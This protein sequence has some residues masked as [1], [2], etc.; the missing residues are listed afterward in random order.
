MMTYASLSAEGIEKYNKEKKHQ[1]M[2]RKMG[3]LANHLEENY[4]FLFLLGYNDKEI[5]AI[6]NDANFLKIADL[7]RRYNEYVKN[8]DYHR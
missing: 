2:L 4:A 8:E 3:Y 6:M 7:L 5:E 1:E